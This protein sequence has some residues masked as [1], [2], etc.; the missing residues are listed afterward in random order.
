MRHLLAVRNL[1]DSEIRDLL[2]RSHELADG[3]P[4]TSVTKQTVFGLLFLEPS[5]RTHVG[6]AAAAVRLGGQVVTVDT[7]RSTAIKF[8]ESWEDTIRVLSGYCDVLVA[9]PGQPLTVSAAFPTLCCPVINGGDVGPAAEH[10]SQALIDVFAIERLRGS[11][12]D[13]TICIVGDVRMRA[14]RSL[15]ALLAR[16][17]PRR[18]VVISHPSYLANEGLE[19]VPWVTITHDLSEVR[20]ADV[21]YV[22]GM[23]HDS[24][25]DAARRGLVLDETLLGSVSNGSIIL[26]PMP[27]LDEVERGALR[28]PRVRFYEQSD[29]GLFVRIAILEFMLREL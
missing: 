21:V 16:N 8:A 14:V 9:R 1:S 24:I 19:Q 11:V 10:P 18:T 2:R 3:A 27:V 17:L 28:D 25:D 4:P 7:L 12:E 5:L 13:M 15:L 23:A 6:F 29:L 22:A 26:S 20:S